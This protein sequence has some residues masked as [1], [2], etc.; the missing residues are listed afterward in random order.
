M[1]WRLN[2]FFLLI[3][4][5]LTSFHSY[6]TDC[7]ICLEPLTL[8]QKCMGHVVALSCSPLHQFHLACIE[9]WLANNQVCPM[10][11]AENP[12]IILP[13]IARLIHHPVLE[14]TV[15][16]IFGGTISNILHIPYINS[17]LA[18]SLLN[19]FKPRQPIATAWHYPAAFSIGCGIGHL[20][21]KLIKA[22]AKSAHFSP[23]IQ[24]LFPTALLCAGALGKLW[25]T[26]HT[27]NA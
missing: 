5:L 6:A 14:N 25:Y 4:C 16:L 27:A 3:F 10:C 18:V 22:I 17:V 1:N 15:G 24:T 26:H 7:P 20:L 11:R 8:S 19:A 21:E 13:R 9:R 23:N 12:L 2:R